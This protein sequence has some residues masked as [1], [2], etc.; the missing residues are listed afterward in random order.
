[1]AFAVTQTV[2]GFEGLAA[3][4]Q[5]G[6][7]GRLTWDT[8]KPN[9]TPRKLMDVGKLHGLG[10]RHRIG[11]AEGIRMTIADFRAHA[12]AYVAGRA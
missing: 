3:A 7:Q 11:L 6:F 5:M 8:S 2:G 4:L 12:D 9:G 1:M 10:F